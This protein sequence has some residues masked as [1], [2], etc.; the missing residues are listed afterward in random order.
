MDTKVKTPST[1]TSESLSTDGDLRSVVQK[2]RNDFHSTV[3]QL[4]TGQDQLRT[5][6]DKLSIGQDQLRTE[7]RTGQGTHEELIQK[8]LS[9]EGGR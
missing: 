2:L 1:M 4:R 7:F 6:V 9:K 5:T 3:D 8:L